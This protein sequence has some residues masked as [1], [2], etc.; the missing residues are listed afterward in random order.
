MLYSLILIQK[1]KNTKTSR[2]HIHRVLDELSATHLGQ[3]P[4]EL[5][6]SLQNIQSKFPS[7]FPKLKHP[8]ADTCKQMFEYTQKHKPT[9]THTHPTENIPPQTHPYK[10]EYTQKHKPTYTHTH[11]TENIHPQTHPHKHPPTNKQ[12]TSRT[13]LQG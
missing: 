3:P 12:E 2:S 8:H 1:R 10:F 9:Y 13:P 11:P 6:Y 4:H 7:K 5:H